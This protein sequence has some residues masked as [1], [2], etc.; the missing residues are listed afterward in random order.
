MAEIIGRHYPL[1]SWPDRKED[2]KIR[3]RRIG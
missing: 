1:K 3:K 2:G